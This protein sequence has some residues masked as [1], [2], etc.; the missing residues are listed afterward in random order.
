M[1]FAKGRGELKDTPAYWDMLM[2]KNT[3]DLS[4]EMQSEIRDLANLTDS[5][6]NTGDISET[7][8]WADA[9]R[10]VF[11]QPFKRQ[12]TL[13]LDADVVHWFKTHA[14]VGRGYQIDINRAISEHVHRYESKT[15]SGRDAHGQ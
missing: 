12:I 6:I 1:G 10:G 7:T 3:G 8:D 5:D 4:P 11:Y 2:S 15:A 9:R 14:R 13:R